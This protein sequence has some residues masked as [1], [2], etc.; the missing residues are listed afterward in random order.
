MAV[1]TDRE[2]AKGDFFAL[3]HDPNAKIPFIVDSI[4][5]DQ[6][7]NEGQHIVTTKD[8]K[9]GDVIALEEALFKTIN[10]NSRFSRCANCLKCNLLS[11]I[12][13]EICDKGNL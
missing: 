6:N 13:C 4:K 5:I 11:L 3:S 9:A 12:P 2:D 8:L 7:P 10:F 1:D